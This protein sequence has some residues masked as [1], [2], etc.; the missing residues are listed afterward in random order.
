[1]TSL[2]IPSDNF[3]EQLACKD[4]E[5]RTKIFITGS[6]FKINLEINAYRLGADDKFSSSISI[7]KGSVVMQSE[8]FVKR[9][10]HILLP[11]LFDGVKY[12]VYPNSGCFNFLG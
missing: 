7:P 4:S 8:E 2:K 1:M 10:R 5:L 12:F 6:T 9:D 11:I 3:F